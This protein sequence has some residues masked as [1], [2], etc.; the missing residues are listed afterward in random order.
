M[1]AVVDLAVISWVAPSVPCV[2]VLVVVVR[3]IAWVGVRCTCVCRTNEHNWVVVR[4]DTEQVPVRAVQV[5][6]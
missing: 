6:G 3:T 4:V 5:V 1:P 2:V